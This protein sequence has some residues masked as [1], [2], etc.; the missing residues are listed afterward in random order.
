MQLVLH[1][2]H[3]NP[4]NLFNQVC[5]VALEVI[6]SYSGEKIDDTKLLPKPPNSSTADSDDDDA[7][8][9]KN[10]S[11][12][13][14]E[15]SLPYNNDASDS[16]FRR[17]EA[18]VAAKMD[19]V[20]FQNYSLAKQ[21]KLAESQIRDS[22][23]RCARLA[24]AKNEAVVDEDYDRASMI[25][26]EL[27]NLTSKASSLMDEL[28][29]EFE[30]EAESATSPEVV[31]P[32]RPPKGENSRALMEE[33]EANVMAEE[34]SSKALRA[35]PPP[36]RSP[37]LKKVM[38]AIKLANSVGRA[39]RSTVSDARELVELGE[40]LPAGWVAVRD[41][42]SGYPYY[43]NE[44][45]GESSWEVPKP[46]ELVTD[47]DADADA[48]AETKLEP[49]E[50]SETMET[51]KNNFL[52]EVAKPNTGTNTNTNT[53]TNTPKTSIGDAPNVLESLLVQQYVDNQTAPN[54]SPR[55]AATPREPEFSSLPPSSPIVDEEE[56]RDLAREKLEEDRQ[57]LDEE[58][59]RLRLMV[60]EE[61]LQIDEERRV[62]EEERKVMENGK[63]ELEDEKAMRLA[64]A[65]E[66]EKEKEE[67][68]EEEVE[69]ESA[70]QPTPLLLWD[71]E[72]VRG[73]TP[74]EAEVETETT[75]KIEEMPTAIPNDEEKENEWSEWDEARTLLEVRSREK[76]EA[77]E[78]EQIDKA[79]ARDEESPR[80]ETP[81]LKTAEVGTRPK[82]PEKLEV[83]IDD[84][85]VLEL[86]RVCANTFG[87]TALEHIH[88]K[89]WRFR[90][91]VS[92]PQ[93]CLL[94]VLPR[95]LTYINICSLGARGLR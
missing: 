63:K 82:S 85:A 41:E 77:A 29:I 50:P 40:G 1:K 89:D 67:E 59:E 49:K 34:D 25:K 35:V 87:T 22:A 61:K 62:L 57:E 8:T 84:P 46:E 45:T 39:M 52:E 80:G 93:I 48:D 47:A 38:N 65:K 20:K 26:A 44:G 95:S 91:R 21:I 32:R 36:P 13:D 58:K 68:E 7:V 81:P 43:Y 12:G 72:N 78:G 23:A 75:P 90:Q 14:G 71:E 9:E 42:E 28:K 92:K 4:V 2:C 24:M 56:V 94:C 83:S 16:M 74:S 5:V 54:I 60:E 37:R 10:I 64:E 6:G 30:S 3:D 53:N 33:V 55:V 51:E 31:T 19:A 66:K 86:A 79:G 73:N 70:R 15:A 11:D 18:V 88:S 27:D 76:R 17:V 69:T